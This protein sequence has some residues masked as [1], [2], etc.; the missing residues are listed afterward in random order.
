MNNA[1]QL[2]LDLSNI[3]KYTRV[4]TKVLVSQGTAAPG[5]VLARLHFNNYVMQCPIE[6]PLF[7]ALNVP[8]NPFTINALVLQWAIKNWWIVSPIKRYAL[9]RQEPRRSEDN[10]SNSQLDWASFVQ[11]WSNSDPFWNDKIRP[12]Q[13]RTR[14]NPASSLVSMATTLTSVHFENLLTEFARA[15]SMPTAPSLIKKSE[16]GPQFDVVNF[17]FTVPTFCEVVLPVQ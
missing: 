17:Y 4:D 11:T 14:R 6:L 7:I 12:D 13:R 1:K 3:S 5:L 2:L 15:F 16:V 10:L 8:S 9:V